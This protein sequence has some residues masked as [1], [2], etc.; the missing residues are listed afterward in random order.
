MALINHEKMC[1]KFINVLLLTERS[2]SGCGDT[3]Y[4]DLLFQSLYMEYNR[5]SHMTLKTLNEQTKEKN[6]ENQFFP[7]V[8]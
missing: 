3:K 8:K 2:L 5:L 1:I 4:D 6:H 7:F